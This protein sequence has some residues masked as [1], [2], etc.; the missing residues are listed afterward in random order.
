M[1]ADLF[2]SIDLPR[3]SNSL[4]SEETEK[5]KS[6]PPHG[7]CCGAS[8]LAETTTEPR[9][10]HAG[11]HAHVTNMETLPNHNGGE[12]RR[13]KVKRFV[14]KKGPRIAGAAAAIG[15]FIFNVVTSCA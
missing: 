11:V 3:G 7:H 8:K 14:V 4:S 9:R 10:V 15:M 6:F 12:R 2:V 13:E 5:S 1:T